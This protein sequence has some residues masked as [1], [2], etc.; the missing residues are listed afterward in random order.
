ML[1][2]ETVSTNVVVMKVVGVGGGGNNAVNRMID[3]GLKDIEFIA[4]NTD[5]QVLLTSK[6]ITKIQIG[7]KLT[8]G[9]G[10]GGNPEIGQK[11]A[12]ESREDIIA[13]LKGANL[14]FVTAGMGGGTGTGAAPVVASI[15]KE[16]G[17]LTVGVVTKPFMT[18]G[19]RRG[20]QAESGIEELSKAVDTLVV[21]PNDR[22]LMISDKHTSV[23]EA[24]KSADDVLR[25]SIQGISD[26]IRQ[27]GCINLDFADI[28][29]VMKDRGLAHMGIGHAKGE[30]KAEDAVK[31]AINSPLLE[32]SIDGAKGV[33]LHV[34]G[35]PELSMIE[36]NEVADIVQQLVDIDA[37][38]IYGMGID[39]SLKDEIIVTVIATGFEAN[40]KPSAG[41]KPIT[42]IPDPRPIG[43]T[44]AE[45]QAQSQTYP[46]ENPV[47]R[48]IDS[49]GS[50]KTGSAAAPRTVTPAPLPPIDIN[51]GESSNGIEIPE[52]L[53]GNRN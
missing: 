50:K 11:A 49:Y 32:T 41:R 14:V 44:S 21:I 37:T 40:Q 4:V 48:F 17:I 29:S 53:K 10:A 33:L 43:G 2:L 20:L 45:P 13:A 3:C 24:F 23:I 35:G 25:Q 47:D 22:L 31:M 28:K 8:K 16:M 9:L 42:S 1:E 15:A 39:E 18:E 30:N 19:R 27:E 36:A 34:T 12:E 46:W 38:F 6:A 5:K 51:D 52:W 7:E 26:V